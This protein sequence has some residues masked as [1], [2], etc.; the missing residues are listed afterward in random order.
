M[1]R[2]FSDEEKEYLERLKRKEKQRRINKKKNEKAGVVIN[3]A[4][5]EVIGEV[6]SEKPVWYTRTDDGKKVFL[7]D[8]RAEELMKKGQLV[9][10]SAKRLHL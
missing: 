5:K 1:C 6:K 3:P 4:K 2:P 8:R 9:M 7:S 10:L